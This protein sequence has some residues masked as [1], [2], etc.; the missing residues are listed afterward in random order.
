MHK[1]GRIEAIAYDCWDA[2]PQMKV[3]ATE[4]PEVL[5]IEPLLL[6]DR[7]GFFL[8]TYQLRRYVEAGIAR[9]FVQDNL[10]RSS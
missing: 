6:G 2:R 1:F 4:L 8:E 10:S 5:I 3:V 9:P 7:R